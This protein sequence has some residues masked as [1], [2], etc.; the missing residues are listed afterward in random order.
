MKNFT[1]QKE[2]KVWTIVDVRSREEFE[3]GHVAESINIPIQELES[4]FDEFQQFRN[5]ILCCA[6]GSRSE[7]ARTVLEKNG[8]SCSNGGSWFNV[9]LMLKELL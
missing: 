1:H 4:H 6:S 3:G 5:I 9:N 7:L 2:N 8:I